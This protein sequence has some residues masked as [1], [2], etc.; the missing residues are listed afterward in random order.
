VYKGHLTLGNAQWVFI[1]IPLKCRI[2]DY[3]EHPRG[4]KKNEI[5]HINDSSSL[6]R[7]F[8]LLSTEN[9]TLQAVETDI[10]T[11][12]DI[13]DTGPFPICD[14]NKYEMFLFLAITIRMDQ[15][16]ECQTKMD[17]LYSPFYSNT[18]T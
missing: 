3:T 11:I 1:F 9:I 18:I 2:Y 15:L 17:Q 12:A 4:E 16:T 13:L 5:A 10:V 6:L 8:L 14:V 7:I